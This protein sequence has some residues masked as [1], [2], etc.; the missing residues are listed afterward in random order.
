MRDTAGFENAA[1]LLPPD[2]RAAALALPAEERVRAEELRLRGGQAPALALPEGERPYM[3]GRT[4]APRDLD[5]LLETATRASAHTALSAVA[6]GFITV[7]GGCRVGLCGEAVLRDGQVAGLRRLSSV[8]VRIPRQARGCADGVWPALLAGGFRDTL[9]LSPPGAGKTTLLRELVRRLSD[10][11]A[12]V[13]LADERGEVAGVWEGLPML[14][15][16]VRTDIVTG[17]PKKQAAMM[18]LRAMTP[19]ILAMDEITSPEDV[20]A[21]EAA[22]GCGVRLLAT[23]HARSA[24]ELW[25]RPVYVRLLELGIFSRFVTISRK[26]GGRFY[27]VGEMTSCLKRREPS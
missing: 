15:V 18:L 6:A 1:A 14:D 20:D 21:V 12:R 13:A 10:G 27:A 9:L 4:V 25:R 26:D 3:P 11:G 19:D 8:S 16:G 24:D 7:K 5:G 22:A 23:A 2:I 17:A